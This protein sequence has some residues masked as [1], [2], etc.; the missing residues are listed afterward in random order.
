MNQA[1]QA[2]TRQG[3][4]EQVDY[5]LEFRRQISMPGMVIVKRL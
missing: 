4:V 5:L 2:A 3:D 1:W